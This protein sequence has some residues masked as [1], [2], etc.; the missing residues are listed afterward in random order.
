M[1]A[2]E[3]ERPMPNYEHDF[4]YYLATNEDGWKCVDCGLVPGEPPGFSPELDR[5]LTPRKVMA[6][7]MTLDNSNI[8][9]VSNGTMGE[10]LESI[11][12]G[13]CHR[14]QRFDQYSIALYLLDAMTKSHAD[15]WAKVSEGVLSGND[16]RTRCACGALATI[17]QGAQ[18]WCSPCLAKRPEPF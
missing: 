2:H 10:S 8:V 17:M 16:P 9:S 11:V 5:K 7:L 18:A 13:L 14:R 4:H 6:V 12:A 15:Y 3:E 1:T